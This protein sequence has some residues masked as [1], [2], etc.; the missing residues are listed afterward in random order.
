MKD[1]YYGQLQSKCY[2]FFGIPDHLM[3]GGLFGRER[4]TGGFYLI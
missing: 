3:M 4:K 2:F 1:D